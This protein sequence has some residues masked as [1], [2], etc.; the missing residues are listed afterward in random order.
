MLV[1]IGCCIWYPELL[2]HQITVHGIEWSGHMLRSYSGRGSGVMRV[3]L[4]LFMWRS[5]LSSVP[6]YEVPRG[7]PTTDTDPDY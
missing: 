4:I 2:E 5:R 6:F 7:L 3:V 1:S